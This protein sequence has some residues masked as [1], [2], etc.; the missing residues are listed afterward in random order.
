MW[1]NTAHLYCK[2]ASFKFSTLSSHFIISFNVVL[3]RHSSISFSNM[4]LQPGLSLIIDCMI[5]FKFHVHMEWKFQLGLFK[6]RLNFCSLYRDEVFE[7][8]CNSIFTLLL[9]MRD[10]IS[11]QFNELKF[12]P[13]VKIAI[14]AAPTS[15][16]QK[17]LI[18]FTKGS[19]LDFWLGP[20]CTFV[21]CMIIIS[22]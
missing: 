8:N 18:I 10:E 21:V 6:L 1:T 3:P 20:E 19:I 22:L 7:C 14:Q 13:R 9:T 17:W 11:S 16:L 5:I 12:H 4:K 15:L 2:W